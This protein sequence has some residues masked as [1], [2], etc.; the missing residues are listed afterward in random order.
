MSNNGLGTLLSLLP[1]VV[2]PTDI[3]DSLQT[4]LAFFLLSMRHVA[5]W[6]IHHLGIYLVLQPSDPRHHDE[7]GGGGVGKSRQARVM[8][9]VVEAE[10][11]GLSL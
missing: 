2:K 9:A 6:S 11:Q 4:S 3:E 1:R 8:A 10:E 5:R 7:L